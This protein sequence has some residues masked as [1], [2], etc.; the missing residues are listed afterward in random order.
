MLP[1]IA[2]NRPGFRDW[3]QSDALFAQS[4]LPFP[5]PGDLLQLLNVKDLNPSVTKFHQALALKV[6]QDGADSFPISAE[7]ICQDLV[8]D[9]LNHVVF[10]AAQL[11]EES[12]QSFR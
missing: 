1:L 3:R 9:A 6:P 8:A 7:P 12:R 10:V 4:S 5:D 11:D 2:A